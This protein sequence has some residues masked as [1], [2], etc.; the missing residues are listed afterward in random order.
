MKQVIVVMDLKTGETQVMAKGVKGKACEAFL[1]STVEGLGAVESAQ[2]TD[3]YYET[4][5]VSIAQKV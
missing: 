4:Q 5:E 2:P 1:R 3:E